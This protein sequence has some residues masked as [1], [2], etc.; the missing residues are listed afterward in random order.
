MSW[1]EEAQDSLVKRHRH[2]EEIS[3]EDT[4]ANFSFRHCLCGSFYPLQLLPHA[5]GQSLAK[6]KEET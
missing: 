2:R 6:M 1:A 5:P 3:E 4:L